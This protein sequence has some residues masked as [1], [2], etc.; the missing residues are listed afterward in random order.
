[1]N[2]ICPCSTLTIEDIN[3]YEDVHECHF[4]RTAY[5]PHSDLLTHIVRLATFRGRYNLF[6]VCSNH[7]QFYQSQMFLVKKLP[8]PRQRR[9]IGDE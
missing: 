5:G 4:D 1:M 6:Y 9:L 7:A 2:D 3:R 8:E